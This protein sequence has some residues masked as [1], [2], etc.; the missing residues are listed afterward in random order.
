MI[1]FSW[2]AREQVLQAS[3]FRNGFFKLDLRTPVGCGWDRISLW[4][5]SSLWT[6]PA[7]VSSCQVV[8]RLCLP[9]WKGEM[10]GFAGSWSPQLWVCPFPSSPWEARRA[11][12]KPF[13]RGCQQS[14]SFWCGG[15][16]KAPLEPAAQK[17]QAGSVHTHQ[18]SNVHR[19]LFEIS[20]GSPQLISPAVWLRASWSCCSSSQLPVREVMGTVLS[21]VCIQAT[22]AQKAGMGFKVT[23][24]VAH[25]WTP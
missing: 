8:C 19:S 10:W 22:D 9:D 13:S 4:R 20:A 7:P 14:L 24:S 15:V 1:V 11:V 3:Y 12:V 6:T 5:F 18:L 2:T 21:V 25:S 17:L 16:S 23:L